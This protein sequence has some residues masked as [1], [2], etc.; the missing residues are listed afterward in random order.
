MSETYERIREAASFLSERGARPESL[1]ILGTGLGGMSERFDES[2][3]V[4]YESIPHF[5]ESTA[6]GHAGQLV[7]G[8][9]NGRQSMV[10]EGRFHCYEGYTM[11]EVTRPIRVAAALGAKTLLLTSAVGGLDSRQRLGEIVVVEDHI[12]L[13]G[14]SPLRGP[15]DERI[16]PRFPDMSAPYD[17]G[18]LDR[19]EALAIKA[20]FRLSRAVHA[21]VPGPQ[22]ETR[23]EYRM[24]RSL[25][26]DTVGMSTV[27]ECIAAV[28]AGMRV[29]ALAV[30]TDLGLPDALEAVDIE[31][32]IAIA[33]AAAPQLEE[34][35]LGLLDGN[36]DD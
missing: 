16:G 31:R 19:A 2:I 1:V 29:V 18:L 20:G 9:R 5:P 3:A 4:P 30:V 21:A 6:P 26:A 23:A 25:G 32:I 22:L 17:A 15:N 12:N 28:H 36:G 13:M 14:D 8:T 33:N 27:P 11:D 10:M 34:L 7:L 24:L 35:V